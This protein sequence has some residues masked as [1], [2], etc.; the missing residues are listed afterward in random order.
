MQML[1]DDDTNLAELSDEELDLAWDLWFDL[2]QSTNDADPLYTHG[3]FAGITQVEI[4][5]KEGTSQAPGLSRH[6]SRAS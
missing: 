5:E 6:S 1:S 4:S 3:V 2:A